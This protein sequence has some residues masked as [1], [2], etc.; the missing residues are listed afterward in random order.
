MV[1]RSSAGGV[2]LGNVERGWITPP[3][4]VGVGLAAGQSRAPGHGGGSS[5]LACWPLFMW[6][7]TNDVQPVTMAMM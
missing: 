1:A 5:S 4:W 3:S 2:G 7:K 6:L